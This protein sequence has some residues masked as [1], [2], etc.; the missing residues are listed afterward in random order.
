VSFVEDLSGFFST[1]DFA[2]AALYNGATTVNGIFDAAYE[3]PL[4]NAVEGAAPIFQCAAADLLSVAHGDTFLI[5]AKTYKVRGVEP[6]GTGV[7]LLR[8]EE[9]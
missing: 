5:N 1:A 6:D 4:G 8:L 9:Q 7:M 3:E 2:V